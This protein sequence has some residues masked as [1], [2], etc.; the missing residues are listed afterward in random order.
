MVKLIWLKISEFHHFTY[1]S[2]EKAQHLTTGHCGARLG[3]ALYSGVEN[4]IRH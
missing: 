2:C 1:W 3:F 4:T